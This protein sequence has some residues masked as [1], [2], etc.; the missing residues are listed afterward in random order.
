MQRLLAGSAVHPI[1]R[2]LAELPR[3]ATVDLKPLLEA[4][5]AALL[6]VSGAPLE[7]AADL[8]PH[9][10]ALLGAPLLVASELA[11]PTEPIAVRPCCEALAQADYLLRAIAG[12][13]REARAGR[14]PFAVAELLSAGIGNDDLAADVPPQALLRY[15]A[16]LR[17]RAAGYCATAERL[18]P[19]AL[20]RRH[21]HL[22]VLAALEPRARRRFKDMLLAWSAA[23]RA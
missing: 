18:L 17:E 4:V 11:A 1:S 12:Y 9:A 8:K 16:S 6:Q 22:L 5:A 7:T 20:R 19:S 13:R 3:A 23:R 21:R 14:V 2:Y 10:Y 15:L